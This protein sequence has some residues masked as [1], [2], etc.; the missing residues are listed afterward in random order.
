MITLNNIYDNINYDLLLDT[1]ITY[2]GNYEYVT[3]HLNDGIAISLVISDCQPKFL[4]DFVTEY[5]KYKDSNGAISIELFY[6][7]IWTTKNS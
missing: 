7:T 3:N 1:G 4:S 6:K 2:H 5:K